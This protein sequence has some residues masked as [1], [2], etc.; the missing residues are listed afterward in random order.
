MFEV[1][2]VVGIRA[3]NRKCIVWVQRPDSVTMLLSTG[4]EV[5]AGFSYVGL[6]AIFAGDL[7]NAFT[8]DKFLRV[9]SKSGFKSIRITKN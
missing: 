5:S 8:I 2:V 7:I 4:C 9:P 6:R 1:G 3:M